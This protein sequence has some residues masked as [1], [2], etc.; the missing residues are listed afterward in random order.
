MPGLA[1]DFINHIT[2]NTKIRDII[3]SMECS[4][5]DFGA[6][7]HRSTYQEGVCVL[8]KGQC[9]TAD[10][11]GYLSSQYF[12]HSRALKENV[13]N[14]LHTIDYSPSFTE[15]LVYCLLLSCSRVM[16]I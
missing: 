2:I 9:L 14:H 6:C 4:E 5:L 16:S 12:K 7:H 13:R 3:H 15:E 10:A 11:T 1:L 8:S